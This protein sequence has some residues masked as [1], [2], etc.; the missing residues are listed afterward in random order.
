M[1]YNYAKYQKQTVTPRA[2]NQNQAAVANTIIHPFFGVQ[3]TTDVG[4]TVWDEASLKLDYEDYV[5]RELGISEDIVKNNQILKG[6]TDPAAYLLA[7][8]TDLE[9]IGIELS[10]LY[11]DEYVSAMRRGLSIEKSKEFALNY[12]K[13]IKESKMQKHSEK[14]P[15]SLTDHVLTKLKKN[16]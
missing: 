12:V 1:P 14:Y 16:I 7:K 2:A 8:N 6:L 11:T 3:Y 4:A 5:P 10:D 9:T 15:T 13:K